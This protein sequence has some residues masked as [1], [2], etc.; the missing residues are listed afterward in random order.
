MDTFLS[1]RAT[2]KVFD[3]LYQEYNVLNICEANI[4]LYK[5]FKS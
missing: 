1:D 2:D 4:M 5:K 3:V